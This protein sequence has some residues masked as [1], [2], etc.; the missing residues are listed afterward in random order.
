MAYTQHRDSPIDRGTSRMTARSKLR[1]TLLVLSGAVLF[2]SLA[3]AGPAEAGHRDGWGGYGR[4][5]VF[6]RHEIRRPVVRRVVVVERPLYSRR[7]RGYGWR[8][9]SG[10]RPGWHRPW[11]DRPRCWLP[12]RHLCR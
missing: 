4:H 7:H 11:R 6:H 12:E 3:Q 5:V 10:Y 9:R 1:N 8:H 2:G